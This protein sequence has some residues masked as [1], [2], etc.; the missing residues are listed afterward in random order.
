MAEI[1]PKHIEEV[2]EEDLTLKRWR[3]QLEKENKDLKD[4]NKILG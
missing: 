3:V 1:T 2:A 4:G